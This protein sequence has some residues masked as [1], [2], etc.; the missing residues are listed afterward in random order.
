MGEIRLERLE[1]HHLEHFGPLVSDPQTLRFTRIPVPVPPDFPGWWYARY[2][3]G[4][5]DG[6]REAFAILDGDEFLGVALAPQIDMVERWAELGYMVVPQARGRGA[7]TEALRQLTA[8]AEDELGMLRL[9]LLI[10]VDNA[11]SQKV[12]ERAGYTLEGVLR[13]T[14]LKE[15]VREDVQMWSRIPADR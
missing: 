15:G 3:Q 5:R 14:Y 10:S 11:G 12:A 13:N 1:P 9:E 8:W 4:R 6:T 7:A 2:E